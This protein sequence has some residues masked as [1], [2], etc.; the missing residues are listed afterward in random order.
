MHEWHIRPVSGRNMSCRGRRW[1]IRQVSDHTMLS[2]VQD[3]QQGRIHQMLCQYL[4]N[5]VGS[6]SRPSPTQPPDL[7]AKA[8]QAGVTPDKVLAVG[9]AFSETQPN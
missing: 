3:M 9:K 6:S 7:V 5:P 8:Q 4:P 1:P 2:M